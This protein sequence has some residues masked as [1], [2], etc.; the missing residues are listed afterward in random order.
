MSA[1]ASSTR[2]PRIA[3]TTSR[4]FRGETRTPFTLAR[5]SMFLRSPRS[6]LSPSAPISIFAVSAEGSGWRELA[7]AMSDHLLGH[8]NRHVDF[9]VVDR[10]RVTDHPREDRRRSCP[11]ADHAPLAR[12]IQ[13]SI[14]SC[15]LSS[16]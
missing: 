16:M 7:E 15:N 10:H 6:L 9:P 11:G 4:A 14:F 5:T 2:F 13:S 8:E 1:M 12:A 3:S